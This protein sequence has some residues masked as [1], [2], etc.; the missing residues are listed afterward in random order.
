LLAETAESAYVVA[1]IGEE[2]CFV[3][4][5]PVTV[6]RYTLYPLTVDVLAVQVSVTECEAGWT[7]VP[8]SVIVAGELV[9]LL[10][11]VTLPGSEP[12][13]AGVKVT[14]RVAVDPAA[15]IWPEETPL[16]VYPAP[17]M[18][19]LETVTLEFPPLVKVTERLLLLPMLMLEKFKAFV[20]GVNSMV[21]AVTVSVAALL[22]T[23]PVALL[24][25]TVNCEP[26]FEVVVAGV[27]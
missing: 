8:E 3:Y 5:P 19:T 10:V 20:L 4:G 24:T 16:A 21:D 17:E 25:V 18:V 7:P 15:I 13:L 11:T 26:L 1:A 12:A 2:V 23:L 6:D 14:F 9:A 22:V 27:V